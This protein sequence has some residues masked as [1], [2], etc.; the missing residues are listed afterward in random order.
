MF[1]VYFYMPLSLAP[2]VWRVQ[3]ARLELEAELEWT[4]QQVADLS[5]ELEQ[6][7]VGAGAGRGGRGGGDTRH[8]VC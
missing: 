1:G 5:A 7:Q 2:P 6:A 4:R 8:V 3:D